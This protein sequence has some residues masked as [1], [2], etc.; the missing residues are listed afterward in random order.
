M[1]ATHTTQTQALLAAISAWWRKWKDCRAAVSE[2][3]SL[4]DAELA[5]V[6]QDVGLSAPQLR[7]LAG[8]WPDSADLLSQRLAALQLDEAAVSQTEPGVLRDLQRVCSMC[9]EQPHCGHDID[10]DPTNPEWR[11][12]C[13]NVGTLDALEVERSMRRL[14][15]GRRI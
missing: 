4:G 14:D 15:H 3:E 12:Y 7:T 11:E 5:H 6:A 10:R 1:P 8:K 2:V 13:P 9:L